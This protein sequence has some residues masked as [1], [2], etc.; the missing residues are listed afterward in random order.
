MVEIA[1]ETA[2]WYGT[3]LFAVPLRWVLV[4]DPRGEFKTQ[5]LLCVPT[6]MLI[7]RRS[8]VGLL[9]AGSWK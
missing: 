7:H 5:A 2:V 8:S 4:R 9:C 3:G 1:S 6:S